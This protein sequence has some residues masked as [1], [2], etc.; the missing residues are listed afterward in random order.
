MY[1]KGE[2][3]IIRPKIIYRFL[4]EEVGELLVYYLWL[5]QS[6]LEIIQMYCYNQKTFGPW[7]QEPKPHEGVVDDEDDEQ[8]DMDDDDDKED[9]DKDEY[10]QEEE[11]LS[12]YGEDTI[13]KGGRSEEDDYTPIRESEDPALIT[14]VAGARGKRAR[15]KA[16]QQLQSTNFNSF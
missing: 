8:V 1:Y 5:V 11:L 14:K 3:Y 15:A 4:P 10:D 13:V 9:A 2:A 12:D 6:F 16:Q 7:L